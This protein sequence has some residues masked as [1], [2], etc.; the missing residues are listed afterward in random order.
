M[1][2]RHVMGLEDMMILHRIGHLGASRAKDIL[3]PFDPA[4]FL[5][6]LRLDSPTHDAAVHMACMHI[7]LLNEALAQAQY[8]DR[9]LEAQY[10][11]SPKG[12][13]IHLITRDRKGLRNFWKISEEAVPH[14]YQ[15]RFL[16]AKA[17]KHGGIARVL[18]STERSFREKRVEVM[19]WEAML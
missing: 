19:P 2:E 10:A 4:F 11:V 9:P 17:A 16:E 12:E 6:L 5:T 8:A 14:A 13:V 15:L 1:I 3:M 7:T 18:S